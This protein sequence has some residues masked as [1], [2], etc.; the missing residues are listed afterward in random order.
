M[1][2]LALLG[3]PADLDHPPGPVDQR[4]DGPSTAVEGLNHELKNDHSANNDQAVCDPENNEESPDYCSE[5]CE[6]LI[7]TVNDTCADDDYAAIPMET[8]E[9]HFEPW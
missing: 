4:L 7:C 1:G 6:K 8:W 2:P 3:F 5:K 9:K